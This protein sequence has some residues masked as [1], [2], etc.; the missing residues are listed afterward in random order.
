MRIIRGL[1]ALSLGLRISSAGARSVPRLDGILPVE[2]RL[3]AKSNGE[4]QV[5][6]LLKR[7][8]GGFDL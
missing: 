6:G 8:D 3:V 4:S 1:E 5:V 2:G 7:Q